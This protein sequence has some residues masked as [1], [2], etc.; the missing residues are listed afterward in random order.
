[1]GQ[2]KGGHVKVC[3]T[4]VSQLLGINPAHCTCRDAEAWAEQPDADE[5]SH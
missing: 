3:H 5:V 2:K 4:T 1:M